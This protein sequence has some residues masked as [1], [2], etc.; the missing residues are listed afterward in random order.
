MLDDESHLS[1]P[2]NILLS[3]L[4]QSRMISTE[5]K[6]L[7]QSLP[8]MIS[9]EKK[10]L[11]Q[12]LPRLFPQKER[13]KKTMLVPLTSRFSFLERNKEESMIPHDSETVETNP[14]SRRSSMLTSNMEGSSMLTSNMEGSSMLTS[15]MEEF[16]CSSFESDEFSKL[17]VNQLQIVDNMGNG[18][19]YTGILVRKTSR[20]HG[21]GTMEYSDCN[22][23]YTGQ[24][25]QG[26]WSGFGKLADTSTGVEYEGGFFD[27]H[28]HGLGLVKYPDGRVY[29]A[30]F[31]LGKMNG[32]GHLTWSDGSKYWG[33][34]NDDGIPHGRGKQEFSDGRVY[35]GEFENG[36]VQGHGRM[37]WPDGSW[38][39][40]EWMDGESNGLGM[41]VRPDGELLDEGMYCHGLALTVSSLPP[42]MNM[43]KSSGDFLLYRSSMTDGRTLEGPLPS[44]I[45]IRKVQFKC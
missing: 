37:T 25:V 4:T 27:N 22:M 28:K 6:T 26:D 19:V 38:H 29:D 42:F 21:E 3:R 15:N 9:T 40:G 43:E 44:Q 17:P 32:K 20:P 16:S 24:W 33:H 1:G 11:Y 18:G 35:D 8:P 5:K 14:Q 41:R 39:L 34:W 45:A 30:S 13:K 10:T 23:I 12:S 36:V 31:Q 7:Y 2:G